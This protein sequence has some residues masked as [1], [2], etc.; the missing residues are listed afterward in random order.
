MIALE[1]QIASVDRLMKERGEE[2]REEEDGEEKEKED[3]E[4]KEGTG[5][6]T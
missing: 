4:D 6:R 2:E 5:K 1:E 3:E